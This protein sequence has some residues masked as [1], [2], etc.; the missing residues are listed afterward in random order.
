MLPQFDQTLFTSYY[1]WFDNFL[2]QKG[3]AFT[4]VT[5]SFAPSSQPK[6]NGLSS[7]PTYWKQ[8]VYDSSVS[9]VIVPTGG[10]YISGTNTLLTTGSGLYLDYINGRALTTGSYAALTGAFAHKEFNIYTVGI[11]SQEFILESVFQNNDNL[12]QPAIGI[13]AT[14]YAAPCVILSID[15]SENFGFSFGGADSTNS[16][17]RALIIAKNR[18]QA[19]GI[20]SIFRDSNLLYFPLITDGADYPLDFYNGL[21]TGYYNY[22]NV[23]LNYPN[24]NTWTWIKTVHS[25]NISEQRNE[26]YNYYLSFLEFELEVIRF[27]RQ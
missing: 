8:I 27:P 18:W 26:N 20:K 10:L 2:L 9:G 6:V 15:A 22:N 21:K 24:P 13:S 16:T 1:L 12:A 5:G 17:A 14:K 25:S 4:N 11:D 23:K 3:Q 7:Y 19:E